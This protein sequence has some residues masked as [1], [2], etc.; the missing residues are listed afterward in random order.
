MPPTRGRGR[1]K[2]ARVSPYSFIILG[3]RFLGPGTDLNKL[4]YLPPLNKLDAAAKKHDFLYNNLKVST[5]EV[6]E[7]FY[8]DTEN[9]G[10]LGSLARAAI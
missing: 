2:T 3:H 7:Q 5:E 1:S 10:I 8:R 6:D 9:T 4:K